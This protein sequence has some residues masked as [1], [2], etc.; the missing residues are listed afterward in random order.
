MK[1]KIDLPFMIEPIWIEH[2][3]CQDTGEAF[4]PYPGFKDR[5]GTGAS[6]TKAEGF[7]SDLLILFHFCRAPYGGKGDKDGIEEL[8]NASNRSMMRT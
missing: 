8:I 3:Y 7:R 2:D 4:L 1:S 5:G 6:F